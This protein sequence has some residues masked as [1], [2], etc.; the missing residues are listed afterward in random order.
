VKSTTRDNALLLVV[1][2]LAAV[3]AWGFW[4][5]LGDAGFTVLLAIAVISLLIDNIRLRRK[6]R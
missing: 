5:L 2:T 3:C 1:G 6:L 4:R